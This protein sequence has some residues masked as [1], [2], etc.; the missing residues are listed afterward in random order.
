MNK[1]TKRKTAFFAVSFSQLRLFSEAIII[2]Y[3][4]RQLHKIWLKLTTVFMNGLKMM[5]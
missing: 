1:N 2:R 3:L 4:P 5:R